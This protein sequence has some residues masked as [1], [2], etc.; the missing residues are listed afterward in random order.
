GTDLLA[1]L[2]AYIQKR[3]L[4]SNCVLVADD[5]TWP[6]A[7]QQLTAIL[8]AAGITVL[9]CVLRRQGELEPDE[10]ACGEV[11]LTL[12]PETD[13][14]V[15]VGSGSITDTTRLVAVRTGK[16]FVCVGTAPSMDGYTSVV[17]PLL[18]RGV[19][20]HRAAVCP[21]IIVCDLDLL[22]TAPMAMVVSGVGDVLGKYIAR[23][24]WQIGQIINGER[25]C[26]VCGDM[27]IDAVNRLLE[28]IPAIRQRSEQGIR[29]LIEALLLAGVTIMVIGH[30][31]AVASI[32]H[33]IVHYWDMMKLMEGQ[34]QPTHGTAV[35]I[36]TLQVWPLYQRFA[37]E[38]L[39]QLNLEAI[40]AR[41]ME[42]TQREW[43]LLN[44]YQE[45]AAREIIRENP[46][47]FLTWTEQA[48]RIGQAQAKHLE[49]KAVIDAMPPF[50]QVRQ[51]FLEL[52]APLQPADLD[53]DTRLLNRS[54]HAAKDYRSRYSLFKLLDECGLLQDYLS[55]YPWL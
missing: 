25:Y 55:D 53:I 51:A 7:G 15:S 6:L 33:N 36:A 34:K 22:R 39:S 37:R 24:D 41:R 48:R 1:R 18:L 26:T 16:P 28:H 46:E 11:L 49:L 13:F 30:T 40:R 52:G 10:R 27:V 17:A 32:E 45:E 9:T 21:E 5:N 31:R 3:Q 35:G 29:V 8:Q 50:E 54:M 19:K 44:T 12:Q 47:D 42:R 23:T 43:W 38:D 20:I 14:L 4:G 2:P